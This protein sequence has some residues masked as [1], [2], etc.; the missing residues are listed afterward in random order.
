MRA[1]NRTSGA[2]SILIVKTRIGKA[3]AEEGP[4]TTVWVYVDTS[5]EVGD[6]D[7]LKVFADEEAANR[8]LEEN[9]PEFVAF[10]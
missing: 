2:C 4:M 7:C 1:L 10:E 3:Q 6:P 5:K 8:W 9:D